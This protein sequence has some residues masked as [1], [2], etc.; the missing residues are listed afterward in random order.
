MLGVVVS[1]VV[2]AG[3]VTAC[4]SDPPASQDD[5][6]VV[7]GFYPLQYAAD[8][9]GGDRVSVR[10]LTGA[11]AEPHD[12]ELT[13]QDVAT[14]STADVVVY[15]RA[16]QPAVDDAVAQQAGD[17][18]LDVSVAAKLDLEVSA[19]EAAE[20]ERALDPHFWLDP[21]RLAD[22][23]DA[24]AE[25]LARVDPAGA[26]SYTA[27]AAALRKDLTA[28]DGEL[29]AGLE[30]CENRLLVTSH[31]AFGYFARRYD[32]E[33]V[34]I[35]GLSPDAEPDA[36]AIARVSDLARE[37][38]VR[39]V[40]Y[41]TLVSPDIARTVASETGARTA[42]LDPLEGL[43]DASAGRDYVA[44]MRANL[45]TLKAGQPCS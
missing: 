27:N 25:R 5:V 29:A 20:G 17:H 39:T 34:G 22:V 37:R 19:G 11:G 16:F 33:R 40:Y 14:L 9:V 28:L 2:A 26:S 42:V 43:S 3:G 10:N 44:V 38:N 12:L 45:A 30:R 35:A 32:L 13:P 7:A 18:A 4:G 8:R 41:E 23:A 1:A 24:L 15:L 21:L 6:E 36:A 31:E